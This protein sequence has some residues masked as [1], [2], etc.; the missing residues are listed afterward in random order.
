MNSQDLTQKWAAHTLEENDIH[1]YLCTNIRA[2]DFL[3]LDVVHHV[4]DCLH[5][6]YM[7]STGQNDYLG[8]FGHAVVRD[9][10]T[11]AVHSADD[12]NRQA[13]WLYPAFLYNCAPM[14]WNKKQG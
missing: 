13:L 2:G 14:G 6:I 3:P 4:A 5:Q 1:Y 12:L 11:D 9:S 7:W 10:L 8:S